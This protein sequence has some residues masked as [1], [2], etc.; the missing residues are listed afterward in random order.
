LIFLEKIFK[1][2][3][4]PLYFGTISYVKFGGKRWIN[5]VLCNT[6]KVNDFLE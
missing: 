2:I 1:G 5:G 6:F 3:Y 4:N